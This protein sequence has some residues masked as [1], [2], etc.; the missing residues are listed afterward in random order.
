MIIEEDK[1]FRAKC[2]I[3]DT[4]CKKDKYVEIITI[5]M[6]IFGIQVKVEL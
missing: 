2:K 3:E 1:T 6:L 4:Q 5:L